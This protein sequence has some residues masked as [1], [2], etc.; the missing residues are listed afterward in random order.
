MKN[1]TCIQSLLTAAALLL[2]ACS[3]ASKKNAGQGAGY[4]DE[5]G[6]TPLPGRN[7]SY[8]FAGPGSENVNRSMF[9]PVYFAFDSSSVGAAE[10][11][12]I[13]AVARHMSKAGGAT[14]IVAGFTDPTGTEEYNRQLGE[15]RAL[16]V[17]SELLDRGVGASQIQ[18]VSFGEDMPAQVGNDAKNRRAEFGLVE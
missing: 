12:K 18:T 5:L 7:E 15:F 11:P 8:S 17:R 2:L 9:A 13:E 3:C 16:A 14:I 6:F 1:P 4:D 10:T